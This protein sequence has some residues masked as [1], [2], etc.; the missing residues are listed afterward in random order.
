MPDVFKE[1]Q[2]TL[3]DVFGFLLP[4]SVA[5]AANIGR[6]DY[7]QFEILPSLKGGDSYWLTR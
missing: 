1:L 5:T 2:I 7:G 4:G 3:Y 6:Y